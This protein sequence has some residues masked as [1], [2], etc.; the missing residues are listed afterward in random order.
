MDLE[1][2]NKEIFDSFSTLSKLI[3]YEHGL[4][5]VG[6]GVGQG[7]R[8]QGQFCWGARVAIINSQL[9]PEFGYVHWHI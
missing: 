6:A 5:V 9:L 2:L 4:V 7:Q 3:E 1:D 8:I